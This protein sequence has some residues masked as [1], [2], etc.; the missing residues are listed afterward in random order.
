MIREIH[1]IRN[2][3][4]KSANGLDDTDKAYE[5]IMTN[6][7]IAGG[8]VRAACA[9]ESIKDIDAFFCTDNQRLACEQSLCELGF[10]CVSTSA[11]ANTYVKADVC[12]QTIKKEYDSPWACIETFDF[13]VTMA[14]IARVPGVGDKMTDCKIVYPGFYPDLAARELRVNRKLEYPLNKAMRM[15]KYLQKGY[16]IRPVE[17]VQLLIQCARLNPQSLPEWKK[18]LLGIDMLT[19][20]ALFDTMENEGVKDISS[21]SLMEYVDREVNKR[22]GDEE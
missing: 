8:A 17:L 20:S 1:A 4:N 10:I 22:M 3:L 6:G 2:Y 21:D 12:V 14:Y 19:L 13:T 16:T 18:H 15:V 11:N 5:A 9:R 7:W